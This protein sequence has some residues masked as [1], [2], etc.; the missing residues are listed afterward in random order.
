MNIIV[1]GATGA[2][3]YAAMR[4]L[5]A[6]GHNVIG[7]S[8]REEHA[9]LRFLDVS[10]GNSIEQFVE[11]L[12]HDNIRVDALLNNAGM[13]SKHYAVTEEGFERVMA[14][15]YLSTYRL[16]MRLLPLMTDNA[17]VVSTASL[18]CYISKLG[19]DYFQQTSDQYRQIAS[20]ANSKMAV[21]LF[22]QELH[23]RYGD[24]LRVR[25]TDPGVVDSRIL[26]MDSWIDPLCDRLFRPLCKTPDQGALPA[27]N[28]LL[29]DPSDTRLLLFR[30]NRHKA[31]PHCWQD[32][33]LAQ[34]LWEET[35]H[36]NSNK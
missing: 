6:L 26:R 7:T 30:A 19:R 32:P 5:Q 2:I 34:W 15:N 11:G 1:T 17:V 14:T 27:V 25:L 13:L 31:L 22:A 36:L 8:R 16:T 29:H 12:E 4:Q 9:G 24:R 18:S 20:Y 35:N 33:T 28:A 3:G 21:V 23:R 10:S